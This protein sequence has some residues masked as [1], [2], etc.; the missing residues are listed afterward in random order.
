MVGNQS[1]TLIY[2]KLDMTDQEHSVSIINRQSDKLLVIDAIDIDDTGS[3][4]TSDVPANL[5]ASADDASDQIVLSWESVT[6]ANS[7]TV[8]RSESSGGPYTTIASGLTDTFYTDTDVSSGG[9]YY[10]V[11][12]AVNGDGESASSNEA[13]ATLPETP[14]APDAPTSLVATA[15]NDNQAILLNWDSA[16]DAANYEVK[17][18]TNSGGPYTTVANATYASYSDAD[19]TAGVT[20]Y[21]VVSAVNGGGESANSN[22]VSAALQ[23]AAEPVLEVSIDEESVAVGQE[24]T[25]NILLK[26]VS[27]IYAEDFTINYDSELF[28]YI[29]F[30]EVTGYKVY[31]EP[32]DQNGT[33]RFIVA[34][35]GEEYGI[36]EEQLFL[37]LKFK[38]KAVGTGKVDA[39]KCRIADTEHEFDLAED[40]CLEDTVIVKQSDVNRSGEYTLLDLAID[41]YYY[42]DLAVDADPTKYEANQAGDEFVTDE[43]LVY[44]VNQMLVNT[45]YPLNS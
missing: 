21:F 3:L 37:K 17:R 42:G 7:Y 41:A 16:A 27:N 1:Y 10:Y 6:D 36:N 11:V 33:L 38:A 20:Y 22:E 19:V 2:E 8:A 35:Q 29:G 4:L 34:S 32:T 44:I 5:V 13:S 14:V 9:T 45:N 30:E 23:A 15:D 28:E 18:S 25:S 40:S 43:D 24:F 26:N 31:N 39:S 12:K